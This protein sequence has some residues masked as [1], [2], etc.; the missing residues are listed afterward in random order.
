[1]ARDRSLSVKL[2]AD[3]SGYLAGIKT[4]G[5]ATKDFTGAMSKSAASHKADWATVGQTVTVAGLAIAAGIGMA[6][7]RFADFDAAMSAAS[8]ATKASA[9]D[10]QALRDAAMQAGADTQYSAT[11]AANGITELGKAGLSTSE[12]LDGG[13]TGALSL[14][15]AGQMEV[16]DAAQLSAV[17]MKQFSLSGNQ[18]GHV[19]DLLAAGAG[20]A[21]GS[22][23]D[24]GM[25]LK[26]SGLVAAQ[27]GVSIEE[28]TGTLAAFASAGLIGSDAGTS[29][30]TM[31]QRLNPQS[32]EAADA[33]EALG[34]SAYDSQGSFVGMSALAGQLQTSMSKLTV[35][36]RNAALAT[37]FGSDAVRAAAVLYDQGA[38]G[39]EEW[40]NKVND[41]GFAADQ[42]ARLTDNL[43]GD[44]ERL[45]GS[46]DTALIKS[47]SGAND[48]LRGLSQSLESA[49]DWFGRLPAPV[50]SG[51][52]QVGAVS[53]AVL[54]LGGVVLTAIPKV[55][56][57][58]VA[59]ADMGITAQL[60]SSRVA[61]AAKSVGILTAAAAGLSLAYAAMQGV[62]ND[63]AGANDDAT[64][65]LEALVK[66]G[67]RAEG[68][69]GLMRTG[70]D[71]LGASVERVF[72]ESLWIKGTNLLDGI[73]FWDGSNAG[74]SIAFFEQLD[75][76]L[77]GFVQGG[78]A[79]QA[80]ETFKRLTDEATRQ[81]IPLSRLQ[82]AFPQYAAALEQ[83][84]IAQDG[85]RESTSPTV[86]AVEDY[87]KAATS[88]TEATK[89]Y[90]DAIK[91]FAS[92]ILDA[93]EAN[94]QWA[95]SVASAEAALKSNGQTLADGTE[96]GRENARALDAMTRAAIDNVGAMQAN[97]A[98]QADLSKTVE[99]S[100]AEIEKMAVKFGMS[101]EEAHKYAEQILTIP[102]ARATQISADTSQASAA[103]QGLFSYWSSK[104]I[105][106][107][108]AAQQSRVDPG[109][110]VGGRVVGPGSGTS[111]SIL[112][113]LSNGEFVVRAAAVE[114]Y[115]ADL[116]HQINAMRFADGGLVSRAAPQQ[117]VVSRGTDPAALA[118]AVR[119]ALHG[120]R[121]DLGPVSSITDRVWATLDLAQS[122]EAVYA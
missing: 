43:R 121:L 65:S 118:S 39:I 75:K 78:K 64:R 50:Q 20:K 21:V 83:A 108:V 107:R 45:S 17:A 106:L 31:L 40:T 6:V 85:M 7:S 99:T 24:M 18:V 60:S 92:P 103:I 29:F 9:R 96:K 115:G 8:A 23:E 66:G 46:I 119:G 93:R 34:I 71:D 95:E 51:A 53:A 91:G 12:I 122:R 98:S 101:K 38:A 111:D 94:R 89:A 79:D 68:V 16:A 5:A 30:K 82:E 32:K 2:K 52:I 67:V 14:A 26:Q 28:T 116:L 74:S 4:A 112:A 86:V 11:E 10:L 80:A 44:L 114:H 58:K 72:N 48:A 47:G 62:V 36:Q 100:A 84:K 54:L 55:Q 117:Q 25:A 15:A 63:W 110:A 3:V 104:T 41:S 105:T 113:R 109:Y 13:L 77:A 57:F 76:A 87:L 42:A 49:V 102:A 59:L 70:F 97:G 81:G 90:A 120:A 61:A 56:A 27:T 69:S 37:I 1:M 22:V 88:A 19:A 33:M 35:E 73:M